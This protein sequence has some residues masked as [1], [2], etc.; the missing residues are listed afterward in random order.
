MFIY[1]WDNWWQKDLHCKFLETLKMMC[2]H[3]KT[4]QK[5]HFQILYSRYTKV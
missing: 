5:F 3:R 1:I 4:W 2:Q